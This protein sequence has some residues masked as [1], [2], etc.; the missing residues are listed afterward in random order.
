MHTYPIFLSNQLR[1]LQLHRFMG[2]NSQDEFWIQDFKANF[3]PQ[4]AELGKL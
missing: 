1:R 3:Q 4:N 2:E